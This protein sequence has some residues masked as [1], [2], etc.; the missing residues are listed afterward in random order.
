MVVIVEVVFASLELLVFIFNRFTQPVSPNSFLLFF[1]FFFFLS[2]PFL[3]GVGNLEDS[4]DSKPSAVIQPLMERI[5]G[6]SWGERSR[7]SNFSGSP[8][9]G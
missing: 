2:S 7:W 4:E 5:S 1:L 8:K 9:I 3:G 6:L